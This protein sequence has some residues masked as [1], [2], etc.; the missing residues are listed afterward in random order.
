MRN[1][2]LLL[3][4]LVL[5]D[6]HPESGR[7]PSVSIAQLGGI[8]VPTLVIVGDHEALSL[9]AIAIRWRVTFPAPRKS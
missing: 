5:L 2:T 7:V 8:G 9:A 3:V 6:P 1:L 4:L